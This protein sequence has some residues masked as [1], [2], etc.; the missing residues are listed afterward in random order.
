MKWAERI[1]NFSFKRCNLPMTQISSFKTGWWWGDKRALTH[2]FEALQ[3]Q[4]TFS[5]FLWIRFCPILTSHLKLKL[6]VHT[7][8]LL[9]GSF[10]S[11]YTTGIMQRSKFNQKRGLGLNSSTGNESPQFPLNCFITA[12]K[13]GGCWGILMQSC[14]SYTQIKLELEPDQFQLLFYDVHTK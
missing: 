4:K 5:I 13:P 9:S 7:F 6:L 14:E 11:R 3:A 8:S 12:S 10:Y 1:W 2:L